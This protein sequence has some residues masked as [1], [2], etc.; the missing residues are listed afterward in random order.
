M[1]HRDADRKQV[2]D[3]LTGAGYEVTAIQGGKQAYEDAML[4]DYALILTD[5]WLVGMDGFE[6]IEALRKSGVTAPIAVLTA[7]IT[8]DMV[9]EILRWRISKI[10][11]KPARQK[12]LLSSVRQAVP[13]VSAVSD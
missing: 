12:D 10:L 13:A 8:R 4:N 2:A 9:R 7:Y 6:L 11:L 5:L 3:C 1:D